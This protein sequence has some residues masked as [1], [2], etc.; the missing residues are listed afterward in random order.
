MRFLK[1]EVIK[2]AMKFFYANEVCPTEVYA[3]HF[4]C[5]FVKEILKNVFMENTTNFV[6]GVECAHTEV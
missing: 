5:D 2:I 6:R 1:D 3:I 4:L